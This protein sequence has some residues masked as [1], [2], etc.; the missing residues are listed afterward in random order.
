MVSLRITSIISHEVVMKFNIQT[1][2]QTKRINYFAPSK[3][4][5]I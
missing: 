2:K 3:F 1:L 5:N 4:M